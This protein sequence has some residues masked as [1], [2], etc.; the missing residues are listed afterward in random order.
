[1]LKSGADLHDVKRQDVATSQWALS[2]R[3]LAV[4]ALFVLGT[5]ALVLVFRFIGG[6]SETSIEVRVED[7]SDSL[8][9]TDSGPSQVRLDLNRASVEELILLPGIGP[10]RAQGIVERREKKG[11]FRSLWELAEIRGISKRMI[12]RLEPLIEVN[13]EHPPD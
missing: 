11:A 1:M 5:P 8:R 2:P 3:E 12:K 7:R 6:D 4:W 9:T 13:P 10:R